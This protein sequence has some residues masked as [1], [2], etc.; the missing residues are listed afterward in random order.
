MEVGGRKYTEGGWEGGSRVSWDLAWEIR[1]EMACAGVG[2][3]G[4]W[5]GGEAAG[6][7]GPLAE[8]WTLV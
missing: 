3:G 5:H 8:V 4:R 1:R 7:A 6:Q 2:G